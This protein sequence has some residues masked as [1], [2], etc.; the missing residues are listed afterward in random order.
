MNKGN[1]AWNFSGSVVPVGISIL[2]PLVFW[3]KAGEDFFHFFQL[4]AFKFLID[5]FTNVVGSIS[6]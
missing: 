5:S 3:E 1:P 2:G 6:S 4:D